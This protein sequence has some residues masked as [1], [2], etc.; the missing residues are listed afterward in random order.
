MLMSFMQMD[1][2]LKFEISCDLC[3]QVLAGSRGDDGARPR[4]RS[5]RRMP[6]PGQNDEFCDFE[7]GKPRAFHLSQ[8]LR[9]I[10]GAFNFQPMVLKN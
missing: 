2:F 3:G 1:A 6:H 4:A 10:V 7:F 9:I 5:S 8:A